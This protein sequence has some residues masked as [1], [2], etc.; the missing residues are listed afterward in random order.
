MPGVYCRPIELELLGVGQGGCGCTYFKVSAALLWHNNNSPASNTW[1]PLSPGLA[2]LPAHRDPR[3]AV[4]QD[5]GTMQ[6]STSLTSTIV[7][8]G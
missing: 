2:C 8:P 7:L 6:V 3:T 5:L 4:T 1:D